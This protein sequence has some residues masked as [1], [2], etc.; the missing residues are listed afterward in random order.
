MQVGVVG[1]DVTRR[2]HVIHRGAQV[3]AL[4]R[5]K[6][7]NGVAVTRGRH[8]GRAVSGPRP[9]LHRAARWSVCLPAPD[10]VHVGRGAQR[11][12][13]RHLALDVDGLRQE[14]FGA[15]H[16]VAPECLAGLDVELERAYAG[17]R[18]LGR[19]ALLAGGERHVE[20]LDDGARHPL[21]HVEHVIHG[22]AVLVGPDLLVAVGVDEL[23]RDPERVAGL[24]HAARQR[25]A[26]T[27]LASDLADPLRRALELHGRVARDH[28][29]RLEPAPG[30]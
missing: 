19:A 26:H 14:R 23:R 16:I 17:D 24:A 3:P 2:G 11:A 4:V 8:L 5:R 6:T 1:V 21:L 27:Q 10:Q 15:R 12:Q 22:A 30:R 18:P 13:R 20:G 9:R 28:T 25:V 7:E 29:Q